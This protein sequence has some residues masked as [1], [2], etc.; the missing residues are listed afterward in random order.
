MPKVYQQGEIGSCTANSI[1]ALC[2]YLMRKDPGLM[3]HVYTPSRLFIYYNTRDIENCVGEDAGAQLRD[4]IR[5]LSVYGFCPEEAHQDFAA[6]QVWSY[7]ENRW[8]VRPSAGC[9]EVA[10]REMVTV[11]ARVTPTLT[12]L[13]GCLAEGF[14]VAFG[15]AVYESFEADEVSRTGVVPLPNIN[16]RCFGGHAVLL[17]GY[18][19]DTKTFLVRNSWGED[20]GDKGYCYFPYTTLTDPDCCDDFWTIRAVP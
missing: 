19:N 8:N 9:Y 17:C 5:S 6:D 10:H 1:A 11:A 2:E 15:F 7:N 16:E 14:P 13:Q 18:D 3:P 20:W 4:V 12:Q